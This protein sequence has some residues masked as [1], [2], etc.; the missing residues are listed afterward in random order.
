MGCVT[1]RNVF[2]IG[3]ESGQV[4]GGDKSKGWEESNNL[5]KHDVAVC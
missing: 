4:G 5:W 1:I 3:D 2:G